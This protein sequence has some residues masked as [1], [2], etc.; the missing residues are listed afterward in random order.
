LS[1]QQLITTWLTG[2]GDF[3]GLQKVGSYINGSEIGVHCLVKQA[4]RSYMG[5]FFDPSLP[6]KTLWKNLDSMGVRD[7]DFAPVDICCPDRLNFFFTSSSNVRRPT[8]Q[9]STGNFLPQAHSF[10][11]SNVNSRDVFIDI[12]QICSNAIGLV[13]V[14]LKFILKKTVYSPCCHVYI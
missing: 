4:K 13:E 10:A 1:E 14:P 9:W 2:L 6:P 5:R 12:H 8:I 7:K 3:I 11:F